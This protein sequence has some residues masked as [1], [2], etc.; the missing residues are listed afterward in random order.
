MH[1]AFV[2]WSSADARIRPLAEVFK[3]W[4]SQ[5]FAGRI[6]F[7]FSKEIRPGRIGVNEVYEA[8]NR[9]DLGFIFLSQRTARSPWVIFECGCLNPAVNNGK[10][11]P[12]LFDISPSELRTIC[13]PL[14]EFQAVSI[15]DQSEVER[16]I[17]HIAEVIGLSAGDRIAIMGDFARRYS[18][19]TDGIRELVDAK[20]SLPDR[21]AG[22][23]PYNDNIGGSIN[24]QMPSVFSQFDKELFLVGINLNFLLNLRANPTNFGS[25][26]SCLM[27]RPERR[28]KILISDLWNDQIRYTYDKIV[29]GNSQR[30]FE[31]LNEVFADEKSDVFLE[32]YIRRY[33]GVDRC[34]QVAGQLEIKKIDILM[35]TFWFLDANGA[36]GSG[37]ML[38]APMTA[39]AGFERPVFYANQSEHRGLFAAYHNV[40]KAGYDI[41]QHVLWPLRK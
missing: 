33:C 15:R 34:A 14:G 35:D 21:F 1:Q 2:S 29:F 24:F 8:L 30:E 31:G 39:L 9:S 23:V 40:C 38:I 37:S 10:V 6:N 11:F 17:E 25:L 32:N 20:R 16:L 41:S 22:L 7:F 19:L 27:D 5:L 28:V 26:L 4:V 13:P 36:T 18:D 12:L 3:N